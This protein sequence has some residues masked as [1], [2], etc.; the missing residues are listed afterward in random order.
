MSRF[1][2]VM[3]GDVQ[4]E[5]VAEI[6][7]DLIKAWQR[8][9]KREVKVDEEALRRQAEIAAEIL[10]GFYRN[11][12]G[13]LVLLKAPTGAGKTEIFASLYFYQVASGV[14]HTGR[15][16]V[17]EPVHALLEQMAKRFGTYGKA[18]RVKVEE[19]H[20]EVKR[21]TYLYT[22]PITLTTVD[23][24]AYAYLAQRV[25]KWIERGNLTGRFTMPVGL[26]M[27]AITVFDEAHL[28]QDEVYLGPRALAR[29]ICY[30]INAGAYVV[31]SSATLPTAFIKEFKSRCA[32]VE[33]RILSSRPR[34][35]NIEFRK[36]ELTPNDVDC[37]KGALIIVNTVPR[38]RRFYKDLKEKCKGKKI[39][40]LHSLLTRGDRERTLRELEELEE[41]KRINEAIVV[42]TQT[43]EV[44]IDYSFT[45]LYT[46]LSPLDSLIQRI[47]RVGRRGDPAEILVFQP[48]RPEPYRKDLLEK[49]APKLDSLEKMLGDAAKLGELLDEVYDEK[50]VEDMS[51]KGDSL[52]VQFLDYLENLHLYSLP[53]E[54][55]PQIKP[56]LYVDLYLLTTKDVDKETKELLISREELLR[57]RMRISFSYRRLDRLENILGL[58]DSCEKGGL[59]RDDE[60]LKFNNWNRVSTRE[61]IREGSLVIL[62]DDVDRVYDEA[63]LKVEEASRRPEEEKSVQ[64]A[65]KK[66]RRGKRT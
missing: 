29:I 51:K 7:K 65:G 21:P 14:W 18:F 41:K 35:V 33:E 45:R 58:F 34:K 38:A 12:S 24:Y 40:V 13:R 25:D 37:S 62:C 8:A 46:D 53:P 28:V 61:W 43:L 3:T 2:R 64:T 5:K 30:L 9:N 66:S 4:V 32:T 36:A 1:L 49:T 17:V 10:R 56:S 63:G 47:G 19:D 52:Y 60:K 11:G 15:M 22:A 57:R 16:Y 31:F 55:H 48:E 27:H 44:G 26:M 39:Y 20:G 54:T 50:I 23:S 42:G 59:E 6:V